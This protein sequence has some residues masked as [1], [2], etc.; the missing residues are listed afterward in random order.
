MIQKIKKIKRL[1]NHHN[2]NILEE[3]GN[4]N[5]KDN[6]LFELIGINTRLNKMDLNTPDTFFEDEIV[7]LSKERFL[8]EDIEEDCFFYNIYQ[9]ENYLGQIAVYFDSNFKINSL[10][11][12]R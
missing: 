9:N 5:I 1:I 4:Y 12:D 10:E 3:I 7:N 6:S 8:Y 2:I 11:W